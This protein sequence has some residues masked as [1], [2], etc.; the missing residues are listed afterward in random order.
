MCLIA[1]YFSITRPGVYFFSMGYLPGVKSESAYIHVLVFR[2]LWGLLVVQCCRQRFIVRGSLT[3]RATRKL[4]EAVSVIDPP[5]I[6]RRS[7]LNCMPHSCFHWGLF[8]YRHVLK[9]GTDGVHFPLQS[10]YRQQRYSRGYCATAR[11]LIETLRFCTE[12]F[13]RLFGAGVC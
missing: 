6:L 12:L 5:Q 1:P 11:H 10:H 4:S 2:L 8:S 13:P 9:L 7:T 3:I